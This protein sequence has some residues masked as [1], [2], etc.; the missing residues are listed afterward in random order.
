M[1][2]AG[3]GRAEIV[4]ASKDVSVAGWRL[5]LVGDLAALLVLAVV[6]L[7]AGALVNAFHVEPLPW[8]YR[9]RAQTIG[10]AV[11]YLRE[12]LGSPVA[13]KEPAESPHEIRLEEFQPFVTERKG[14]ILD[15][16]PAVFYRD[17]HIP[18][19]LSLPR[20]TFAEDYPRLR[21]QLE[22][23]KD[24]PIAV[25]C[26]GPDCPDSQL[27]ADALTKLGYRR[28][29]IYTSGWEEWSQTGLPTGRHF[30][31]AMNAVANKGRGVALWILRLALSAIFL[32][33]GVA[34]MR[35]AQGFAESVASFRLLPG[36]LITPTALTLPPLEI[37]GAALA[38]SGG[39]LRR[40]GAFCL[41]ALL[42]AF[43]T[44]LLSALT[45]G[46]Q[47]DCGCFGTDHFDILSPTK[48]IWVAL[49]RDMVLGAVAWVLYADARRQSAVL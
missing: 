15:A 2:T 37:L 17:A 6:A 31:Q 47:V 10:D 41:F 26:S 48:N 16:R 28:L 19:A 8:R 18:G 36:A 5:S 29:V 34:K 35:G 27:V 3:E 11:V 39:R 14:L 40:I 49:G 23:Y 33:A 44:A 32:Y 42:I 25:Y 1:D 4:P 22:G 30:R 13:S 38:L 46:L 21:G 7:L 9:S 24:R 20:E 45:R 43:M 12:P